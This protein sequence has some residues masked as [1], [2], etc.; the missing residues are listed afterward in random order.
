M[1]HSNFSLCFVVVFLQFCVIL[2]QVAG[3]S[4]EIIYENGYTVTTLINGDKS[5]IKVNPQSILHQS[6]PSD[7]FIILDSVASTFYTAL[8]PTT[9]TSNETVMKKLAGNEEFGYVD[10]DLAS[11]KFNKP[12]S[13]SVDLSGNLY[14]ADHRNHAIR[15]ITKS[16]VTTIAG[17]YS[18]KSGH[19]DGPARDASFSD[20]FELTFISEMCALLISDH[21][22]R[23][24]RQISLR[25]EDCSRQSGSVLGTTSAWLLGLGLCSVISL[26][27]GLVIRPYVI[28]YEGVRRHQLPW[29]W[30]HCQMSLERQVPMLCSDLRSA[31]V[32]S[33]VYLRGLQIILLTLSHLSL[34]FR[35][36]P[37]ESRPSSGKKVSLLDM[38]EVCNSSS[39]S[40]N[41]IISQQV[42]DQL[43]D[44]LTFDKGLLMAPVNTD[45][46]AEPESKHEHQ[47]IDGMIKANLA[48]FEGEALKVYS[49]DSRLGLV[50]RR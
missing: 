40:S 37:L 22:N 25:P 4:G 38:D 10:G 23:L 31:V 41:T 18:Q 36:M 27:V 47:T 15:K 28:P 17:G 1:V 32:K 9:S 48:S 8:L 19:A 6:P 49:S 24:V 34:M 14:V 45:E 33:T 26:A 46:I 20:D 42:A 5:N 39:S 11:A 2:V 12:K 7:L 3:G 43:K 35:R 16:G 44:L 30:T 50:R 21:G 29:T 13:F